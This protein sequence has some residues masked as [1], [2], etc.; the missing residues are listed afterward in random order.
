MSVTVISTDHTETSVSTS[1]V[2]LSSKMAPVIW[3]FVVLPVE[4]KNRFLDLSIIYLKCSCT[5][6]LVFFPFFSPFFPQ[7][8]F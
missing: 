4:G 1:I 2:A 5:M 6:K 8:M 7:D 3:Y